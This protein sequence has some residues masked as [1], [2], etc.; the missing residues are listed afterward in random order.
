MMGST[1]L[2]HHLQWADTKGGGVGVFMEGDESLPHAGSHFHILWQS[3]NTCKLAL[4]QLSR[5][6]FYLFGRQK[7]KLIVMFL[8]PLLVVLSWDAIAP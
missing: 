7:T 5:M 8:P 2:W 3:P 6:T 4:N 1:H